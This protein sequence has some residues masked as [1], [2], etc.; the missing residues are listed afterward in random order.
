MQSVW[1]GCQKPGTEASLLGNH[2]GYIWPTSGSWWGFPMGELQRTHESANKRN[3]QHSEPAT[4]E[5]PWQDYNCTRQVRIRAP[6]DALTRD[7]WRVRGPEVSG[8]ER[9]KGKD[10]ETVQKK[11]SILLPT[12]DFSAAGL[13]WRRRENLSMMTSWWFGLDC[14]FYL[15]KK[16]C[17]Y[18]LI[19]KSG[20]RSCGIFIQG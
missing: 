3:D 11:F 12:T 1:G 5:G 9:R 6:F 8:A 14:T 18:S 2:L 13:N 7:I 10:G 20:W 16:K 15:L 4:P 19:P 17:Y